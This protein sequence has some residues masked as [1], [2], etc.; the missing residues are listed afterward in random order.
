[1]STFDVIVGIGTICEVCSDSQGRLDESGD[2][3]SA[4]AEPSEPRPD[5]IRRHQRA[6]AR[7]MLAE[8]DNGGHSP[9]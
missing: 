7:I 2:R 3:G 9:G 6:A 1:M 4:V 8:S 5:A